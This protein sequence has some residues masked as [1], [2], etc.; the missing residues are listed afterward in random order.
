MHGDQC[1]AIIVE[2]RGK[3]S[4]P[5]GKQSPPTALFQAMRAY[6]ML[7]PIPTIIAHRGAL[8]FVRVDSAS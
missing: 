6:C 7:V 1:H 2:G 3:K 4:S 5:V 8:P